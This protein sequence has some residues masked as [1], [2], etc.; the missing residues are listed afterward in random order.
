MTVEVELGQKYRQ[1]SMPQDIWE[2]VLI[3]EN[4]GPI[5][6]ARLVR[7]GS[8]KDMKTLSFLALQDRRLYQILQ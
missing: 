2:V 1:I 6:H 3:L 7:A 5:P 8:S 4:S